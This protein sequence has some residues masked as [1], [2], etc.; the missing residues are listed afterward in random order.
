MEKIGKLAF[1]FLM[2]CSFPASAYAED[3]GDVEFTAEVSRPRISE[4]ESVLLRLSVRSTSGHGGIEAPIFNAPD[5]DVLN[6]YQEQYQNYGVGSNGRISFSH[7][8]KVSKVLRP[9]KT[10]T[11]RISRIELKAK[12]SVLKAPDLVVV[13][14][15]P[16]AGAAPPRGYGGGGAGLRGSSKN[17]V[18]RNVM[19]RAELGKQRAYKGEQVVLN[20]Y[21]YT[22]VQL[23]NMAASKFPVLNG[24]LKEEL[25]LPIQ[26]HLDFDFV[27]VDGVEYRRALLAS[28]ALYPLQE[29]KLKIDGFGIK[30][31]YMPGEA[32]D[33]GMGML[34][35]RQPVRSGQERSEELKLDVVALPTAGKPASFG[36]AVGDFTIDAAVDKYEVRANEAITLTAKIEGA[37]NVSAIGEPKIRWPSDVEIYDTKGR[38]KAGKGGVGEKVFE[39][40]LIPRKPGKVT[41]P[42][43][44]FSFFSPENQTYVTKTTQ[45]ID[46]TVT[47]ASPGSEPPR[48]KS[49]VSESASAPVAQAPAAKET[50]RP[51]LPPEKESGGDSGIPLWRWLYWAA[52]VAFVSFFTYAGLDTAWRKRKGFAARAR[53]SDKSKRLQKARSAGQKATL[54]LAWKDVAE[55]YDSVAGAIFDALDQSYGVGARSYSR[56]ALEQMLVEE[57]GMQA[58]LW[59]RVKALLEY[60]ELVKYASSTG[61]VSEAQAR[62]RLAHWVSEAEGLA[63][64]IRSR[65]QG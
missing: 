40:V 15:P 37:G 11:L 46:I 12:G 20:Y 27:V 60:A 9:R 61:V 64:D 6:E 2:F 47:A 52:A 16:G 29:G 32:T 17:G 54:G 53:G 51:L 28:Y 24:F 22:R 42:G 48:S 34:F 41:L 45:P 43:V 26:K 25:D 55:A 30:Y 49:A 31:D 36:G 19:M 63:K 3:E 50:L 38:S 56:V 10:G 8:I 58:E 33:M 14:D 13:V 44:E 65:T 21:L 5:F 7:T 1:A 39:Y 57:R 35:G 18:V 4:D 23:F 59:G 62:E